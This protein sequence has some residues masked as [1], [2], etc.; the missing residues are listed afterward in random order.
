MEGPAG[1]GDR[2]GGLLARQ[3]LEPEGEV[4][5]RRVVHR[6]AP[7]GGRVDVPE[8]VIPPSPFDRT[9]VDAELPAR[10]RRDMSRVGTGDSDEVQLAG[11]VGQPVVL[12][13]APPLALLHHD[14]RGGLLIDD[15]TVHLRHIQHQRCL[16]VAPGHQAAVQ[17]AQ[18]GL[19]PR[20]DRLHAAP[21]A[22]RHRPPPLQQAAATH[23][24]RTKRKGCQQH[25]H[26]RL[27]LLTSALAQAVD[28]RDEAMA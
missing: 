8:V 10:L 6:R 11:H 28:G 23:R 26:Q 14:E 7:T 4:V 13:R 5:A 27:V 22:A 1:Q 24:L 17:Q 3:W 12:H 16:S 15:P 19:L 9:A 21:Q 2:R 25:T 20:G 18:A